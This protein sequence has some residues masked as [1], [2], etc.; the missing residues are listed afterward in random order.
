MSVLVQIAAKSRRCASPYAGLCGELLRDADL[1]DLEYKWQY[2][3][4]KQEHER[5]S[6]FMTMP[7]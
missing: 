2:R 3:C 7:K 1:A 6:S 4:D 5:D